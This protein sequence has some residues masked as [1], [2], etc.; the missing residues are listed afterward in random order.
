MKYPKNIID[1]IS[2]EHYSSHSFAK[3]LDESDIDLIKLLDKSRA[4]PRKIAEVLSQGTGGTYKA[5]YIKNILAKIKRESKDEMT[6]EEHL[7]KVWSEG[8][9]VRVEKDDQTGYVGRAGFTAKNRQI[10]NTFA[11]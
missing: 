4:P 5:K 3:K 6:L 7:D 9:T 11:L 1:V 2:K 8:G 10:C